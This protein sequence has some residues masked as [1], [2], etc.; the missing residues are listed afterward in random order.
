MSA[1]KQ[2]I[3]NQRALADAQ[4][5]IEILER[6]AEE[7]DAALSAFK[8]RS[9]ML[10]EQSP[11]NIAVLQLRHGDTVAIEECNLAFA[12]L[13]GV[14]SE[15]L[16]EQPIETVLGSSGTIIA[17]DCRHCAQF[18]AHDCE[19]TLA[20][21]GGERTVRSSYRLLSSAAGLHR[22]TQRVL[23][24]QID[25]TESRRVE[26]ALRQ[27]MRLEAIGQLTGG[28]AHEFN[29]LL[30]AILGS[31][32]LL[33]RRLGNES[34]LRWIQNATSAALRGARL[35][36]QLLAYSRK[37]FMD[38]VP[39]DIP[40]CLGSMT[41]LLRGSVG[42]RITFATEYAADTWPAV[43]DPAQL[44]LALLSLVVNARD[45]MPDGGKLLLSTSN[46]AGDDDGLPSELIKGDYVRL[47][48]ADT[49]TG[50]SPDTLARAM[51][52]FFT[53]KGIGAGSGLGLSQAYGVARQLGGT[54]RLRSAL[55]E[56][57]RAEMFLPRA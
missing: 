42:G 3:A 52:P 56:G 22:A 50:M 40:A 25:L 21:P 10:F 11:L 14:R 16:I 35:T 13:T 33:G 49:G 53:T 23:L 45:A 36:H 43:A 38:P 24:T 4:G 41:E 54:L 39:T 1:A 17:A 46:H 57:T 32:E 12:R 47:C 28:V 30:T 20:L 34:Q 6:Q 9:R 8:S 48:V 2:M 18:G 29:N 44:E 26:N 19:Q 51:E 31:L 5:R 27:S 55:G 37:Q 15:H 7:R